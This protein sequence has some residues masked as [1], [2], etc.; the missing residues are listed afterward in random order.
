MRLNPKSRASLRARAEAKARLKSR[1]RLRF[2]LRVWQQSVI[3][4]L[5]YMVI[6]YSIV[7]VEKANP[8]GN[9][10]SIFDGLWYSIV[11]LTTVGYG[12]FY[13][14]TVTGKILGL[15]VIFS[16]LGV[17]G[18]LIGVITNIIQSRMEKR[19]RGLLGTHFVNHFVIVGWDNF[20]KSVTEQIIN[21]NGRIAIVT[22]SLNDLEIIRELYSDDIVFTLLSDYDNMD[23]LSKI[24]IEHSNSVF[25]NFKDDSKSL[26]YSI[27]LKKH[28]SVD[29]VVA[30]NTSELK[31][32][33]LSVG[34]NHVVSKSDITSRMV[35]SYIFEPDVAVYTEDLIQ[36]SVNDND[37]DINEYKVIEGNP[38]LNSKYIDV[39]ADMKSEYDCILIGLTKVNNGV[40]TL[41]KNPSEGV[42]V[43]LNDYLI[44]I[45]SGDYNSRLERDFGIKEGVVR[46]IK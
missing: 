27:N 17:L 34:V 6:L 14:V 3:F 7:E 12:D 11:T 13:P 23:I 19:K 32:T 39:F 10:K 40:R 26:I 31:D 24:N 21:A 1:F 33:F 28:Y 37:F 44:I 18:F 30:L 35:A 4:A 20:A 25:I 22:D 43:E 42:T 41:L 45:A 38:Y 9:I 2:R 29:T 46:D 5:L 16:S 8:D 36:S 15:V